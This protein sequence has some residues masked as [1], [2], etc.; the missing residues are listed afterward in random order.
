ME[1]SFGA[2]FSGVRIHADQ[3][4]DSLNRSLNA[5]AFTTGNDI[6]FKQG[7]YKPDSGGGQK[8]LAHELTHVVQQ[9]GNGNVQRKSGVI[10][11]AV[12]FEFEVGN[13]Q[14]QKLNAPLTKE[15]KKGDDQ[16]PATQIAD[17]AL[18]KESRIYQGQNYAMMADI[19]DDTHVEFVT[20]PP[21]QE[22]SSGRSTLVKTMKEI[23]SLCKILITAGSKARIRLEGDGAPKMLAKDLPLTKRK[24][25][26]PDVLIT[27]RTTIDGEP[28]MTAGIRLGQL[29]NVMEKMS[30]GTMD[31]EDRGEAEQRNIGVQYLSGKQMRDAKLVSQSP[32]EAHAVVDRFYNE[33]KF[34]KLNNKGKKVQEDMPQ[35]SLQLVGLISL[36]RTYIVS[37]A[38]NIAYAKSLAPLMART[39]F[40]EIFRHLGEDEV[41][42]WR[43]YPAAFV[44]MVMEACGMSG[45]EDQPLFSGT[46]QYVS[47]SDLGKL[48]AGLSRKDWLVGIT[49]GK[50]LLTEKN[51]PDQNVGGLLFGL[52]GLR[53]KTDVVGQKRKGDNSTLIDAPIFEFR[54]MQ[55]RKNYQ[56]WPTLAEE[57]FD[58]MV[59]I[60]DRKNPNFTG[61]RTEELDKKL[62]KKKK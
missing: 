24:I 40:G 6:F 22:T 37:A 30:V 12:G 59:G 60:N 21:F 51:F 18:G 34:H 9:N 52:G 41:D 61:A 35:P 23:N 33:I 58:Y 62:A 54:R 1:G 48:A 43:R 15:Q 55:G 4:A 13:W 39:H 2:D 32:G 11:R 27:P 26:E 17:G 53:K 56:L 46:S 16:V 44:A 31:G 20:H 29:A 49:Q 57:L 5:R 14:L 47:N 42:F 45:E 25:Q 3:R 19:G 7:E 36:L 10:Q 28:Q 38:G 50:D 8:L